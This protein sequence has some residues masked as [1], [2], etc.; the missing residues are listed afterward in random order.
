MAHDA[1]A[2]LAPFI[3]EWRLETSL[4]PPGAVR[5]LAVFEWGLDGAFL[6]ERSEIDVP[7]A[8][9]GL[10]VMAADG[11]GYTQHYFDSRGVVRL[12][13]MRFDGRTW[14]LTRE[15]ADFTPLE[16]AQRYVGEFSDDG[17]RIDGR[18]EIRHPGQDW[19]KD[20]DLTYVR[21]SRDGATTPFS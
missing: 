1:I 6:I 9:N 14:T 11:E 18:W 21:E 20:F 3:G 17:S 10:C 15:Q 5:A 12:Y 16:F 8:P 13:R 7:E 2:R 19:A 4:G